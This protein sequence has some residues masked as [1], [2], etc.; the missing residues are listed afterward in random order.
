MVYGGRKMIKVR[1][2]V[3]SVIR[4][5]RSIIAGCSFATTLLR[6]VLCDSLVYM[7]DRW[8]SVHLYVMVDVI[9]LEAIGSARFVRQTLADAVPDACKQ[10]QHLEQVV[11]RKKCQ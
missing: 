5:N 11:S 3:S 6:V 8:P 10:W 7:R 4:L 1:E 2:V 9:T